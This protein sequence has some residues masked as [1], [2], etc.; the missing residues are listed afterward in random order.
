MSPEG[1]G[2]PAG[3]DVPGLDLV[4]RSRRDQATSSRA[5]REAHS[6]LANQRADVLSRR[7]L[8][9][10]QAI[11]AADGRDHALAQTAVAIVDADPTQ[12]ASV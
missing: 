11:P 2:F 3:L 7:G 6:Y 9:P 4:L 10:E 12:R 8:D 5:E 1:L